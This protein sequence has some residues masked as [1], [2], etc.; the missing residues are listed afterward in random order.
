MYNTKITSEWTCECLTN[1]P[2]RLKRCAV[3][4][5]EIPYRIVEKIYHEEIKVQK[6]YIYN[7]HLNKATFD[8]INMEKECKKCKKLLLQ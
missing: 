5:K 8:V 2:L 4:G 6:D 3:C 7:E 1:N